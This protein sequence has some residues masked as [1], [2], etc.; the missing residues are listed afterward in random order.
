MTKQEMKKLKKGDLVYEPA[1][2]RLLQ[3]NKEVKDEKELK[4]LSPSAKEVKK[5]TK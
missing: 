1:E 4:Q 3:Y 2:T 5:V